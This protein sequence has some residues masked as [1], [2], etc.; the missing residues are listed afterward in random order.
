MS[1]IAA[2]FATLV[3]LFIAAGCGSGSGEPAGEIIILSHFP[4]ANWGSPVAEAVGAVEGTAAT[5]DADG[6]T[7]VTVNMGRETL[8]LT[9]YPSH[10]AIL[11]RLQ[12]TATPPV[13]ALYVVSGADG[14]WQQHEEQL[15]LTQAAGVPV[16]TVLL[17]H[18]HA[19]DDEELLQLITDLEIKELMANSGNTG[20][21]VVRGSAVK[22]L[23]GD[24][25]W[26]ASIKDMLATLRQQ[27]EPVL[28]AR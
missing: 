18:V 14:P 10:E 21:P 20:T 6:V 16:A 15:A 24:P 23:E 22:A 26:E 3:L 25:A 1:R 11:N 2:L 17:C 4:S 27:M 8:T 12:N 7:R 9:Q 19:V 13:A 5:T 28:A